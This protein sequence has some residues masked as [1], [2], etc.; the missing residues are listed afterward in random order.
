MSIITNEA[1]R[2]MQRVFV[3][4]DDTQRVHNLLSDLFQSEPG[5]E[6]D[7]G[8]VFGET[9]AGKSRAIDR[10][11]EPH[12]PTR[13]KGGRK[14]PVVYATLQGGFTSVKTINGDVLEAMEER[15]SRKGDAHELTHRF[16]QQLKGQGTRLIVLDECQH[17]V[18]GKT[19]EAIRIFGDWIKG[20][21]NQKICPVVLAGTE[22]LGKVLEY[23]PD[24]IGRSYGRVIKIQAHPLLNDQDLMDYQIFLGEFFAQSPI[25]L[26]GLDTPDMVRRI[27][28]ATSG[29]T[30]GLM[31]LL[32]AAAKR[33]MVR[34]G[35]QITLDDLAQ[36][37]TKRPNAKHGTINAF[38]IPGD[39]VRF[40][41]LA[42]AEVQ[43]GRRKYAQRGER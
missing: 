1:I 13:G 29:F 39:R 10:F 6:M 22:D 36:V 4:T 5:D 9:R 35:D 33:A 26:A 15:H 40:L 30:G 8:I 24:L 21:L 23:C 2:E 32:K 18:R 20:I 41:Q 27:H 7:C 34:Q 31:N 11:S 12:K 3:D 25:K 38:T 28:M 16:I 17:A 37:W 19:P 14:A 42:D 43:E